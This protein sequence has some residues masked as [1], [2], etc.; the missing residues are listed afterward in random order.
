LRLCACAFLF[1]LSSFVILDAYFFWFF[2]PS[3]S[4]HRYIAFYAISWGPVVWVSTGEIFVS[5]Y[6]IESTFFTY[7]TNFFLQPLAIRAKGM[8][9]SLAS[10]WL[11]N[12]GI[13]Y[14]TPY[15]VNASSTGVDGMQAANLGVKVFFIWGGTCVGCFIFT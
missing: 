2:F 11:W 3:L 10:N 6:L 14:A 4:S 7:S 5:F 9:L 12:F 13:S 8:S 15:L 1:F